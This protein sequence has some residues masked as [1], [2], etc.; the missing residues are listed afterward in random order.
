MTNDEK[1]ESM[2]Q[3]RTSMQLLDDKDL[4]KDKKNKALENLFDAYLQLRAKQAHIA[5]LQDYLAGQISIPADFNNLPETTQ[6]I[7]ELQK[8]LSSQELQQENIFSPALQNGIEL[9]TQGAKIAQQISDNLTQLKAK[10]IPV[11]TAGV[12]DLLKKATRIINKEKSAIK[13]TPSDKTVAKV[14]SFLQTAFA[15]KQNL[16]AEAVNLTKVEIQEENGIKKVVMTDNKKQSVSYRIYASKKKEMLGNDTTTIKGLAEL[17][18][19]LKGD[20]S[21]SFASSPT[22]AKKKEKGYTSQDFCKELNIKLTKTQAPDLAKELSAYNT[23]LS[24]NPLAAEELKQKLKDKYTALTQEQQMQTLSDKLSQITQNLQ[25]TTD[26]TSKIL[27]QTISSISPDALLNLSAPNAGQNQDMAQHR[28][29]FKKLISLVCPPNTLNQARQ[30]MLTSLRSDDILW[31]EYNQP[32]Y[33]LIKECAQDNFYQTRAKQLFDN[34]KKTKEVLEEVSTQLSPDLAK[35]V[36]ARAIITYG[37]GDANRE[38][39]P[40]KTNNVLKT[41]G[42]QISLTPVAVESK[43][44]TTSRELTSVMRCLADGHKL[45]LSVL[46]DEDRTR[47]KKH[48]PELATLFK[49]EKNYESLVGQV[50]THNKSETALDITSYQKHNIKIGLMAALHPE[51]AKNI[52]FNESLKRSCPDSEQRQWDTDDYLFTCYMQLYFKQHISPTNKEAIKKLKII[53]DWEGFKKQN[54]QISEEIYQDFTA[55]NKKTEKI[56]LNALVEGKLNECTKHHQKPL[57]YAIFSN[58]PA[59]YNNTL[60]TSTQAQQWQEDWHQFHHL[61]TVEG[62]DMI[63]PYC[64]K[65]PTGYTRRGQKDLCAG[66]TVYFESLQILGDDGKYHDIMPKGAFY[67]SSQGHAISEPQ[68]TTK[69]YTNI[70]QLNNH[71]TNQ[72]QR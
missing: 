53:C 11:D 26:K 10:K 47:I 23:L 65:T 32:Y 22:P 70:K 36:L 61:G 59:A 72:E 14:K 9:L 71:Y 41:C 45:D 5:P 1:L 48:A 8:I 55:L 19:L 34:H 4:P 52:D 64:V 54:K 21:F 69:A 33:D 46:S 7:E 51:M 3:I 27:K 56:V 17:Y 50:L 15:K 66:D 57:K 58:D 6:R 38:P 2:H 25:M 62:T 12:D 68:P 60:I 67:L 63:P 20:N 31:K 18:S 28:E 29:Q 44:E 30:K 40:E 16:P 13:E 42:F 39:D 37:M 49:S 24:Q 43:H 35:K